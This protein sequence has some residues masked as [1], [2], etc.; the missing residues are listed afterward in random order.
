[1]IRKHRADNLI[2]WEVEGRVGQVLVA[3]NN[4]LCRVDRERC[5]NPDPRA[6]WEESAEVVS[7]GAEY[8]GA[9]FRV[10][11]RIGPRGVSRG[12]E[13]KCRLTTELTVHVGDLNVRFE[14]RL[15]VQ[16]RSGWFGRLL[17]ARR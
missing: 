9:G 10:G 13:V 3:V 17:R 8:G 16:R 2:V 15:A 1:G 14:E 12:A 7:L 4:A 6:I 5:I 11:A